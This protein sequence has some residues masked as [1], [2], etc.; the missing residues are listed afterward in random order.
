MIKLLNANKAR[1]ITFSLQKNV[2]IIFCYILRLFFNKV[3][4]SLERFDDTHVYD[5]L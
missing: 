2:K 1:E 5:N 3:K 4:S